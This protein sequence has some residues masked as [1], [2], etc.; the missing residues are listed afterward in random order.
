MVAS[1]S[2]LVVGSVIRCC[3]GESP[4]PRYRTEGIAKGSRLLSVPS[5][6]LVISHRKTL[7]DVTFPFLFLLRPML[8]GWLLRSVGREPR[9]SHLISGRSLSLLLLLLF[10]RFACVCVCVWVLVANSRLF[11]DVFS[12]TTCP[13]FF[14]FFF[15]MP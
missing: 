14:F 9:Q 8:A 3:S 1:S 10:L 2:S 5:S 7:F 4:L 15:S 13:L 11:Y 6:G 12:P